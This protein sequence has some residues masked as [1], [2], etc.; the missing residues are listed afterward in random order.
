MSEKTCW[1]DLTF[2]KQEPYLQKAK[3]LIEYNYVS[4][5]IEELAKQMYEK[6]KS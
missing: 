4:G 1:E 3:Y 5:D 2:V 6:D